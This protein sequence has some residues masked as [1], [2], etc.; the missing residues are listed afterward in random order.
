MSQLFVV[1]LVV[2][3]IICSSLIS[4]HNEGT[5]L[6]SRVQRNNSGID[7]LLKRRR[8]TAAQLISAVNRAISSDPAAV[9]KDIFQQI[10]NLKTTAE[11][12]G[13][14]REQRQDFFQTENQLSEALKQLLF[15]AQKLPELQA[16][17]NL[18]Q[19][20]NII[21]D[22]EEDISAARRS[23]NASVEKQRNF[24]RSFPQGFFIK[25]LPFYDFD[26]WPFFEASEQDRQIL[27]FDD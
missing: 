3:G 8:D 11:S 23:Y 6:D 4:L 17:Q 24:L 19:Y 18:I 25:I 14:N 22:I 5:R 7:V 26:E 21:S 15:M 13:Q 1:L 27:T 10:N 12:L 2:I 16:N 20:Q 9:L